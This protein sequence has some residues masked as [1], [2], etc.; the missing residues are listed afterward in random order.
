M[1]YWQTYETQPFHYLYPTDMNKK[2][3]V[4]YMKCSYNAYDIKYFI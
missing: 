3:S 2:I 1:L 4:V